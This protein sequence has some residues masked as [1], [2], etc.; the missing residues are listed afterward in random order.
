MCLFQTSTPEPRRFSVRA[1]VDRLFEWTAV[2]G[3]KPARRMARVRWITIV[4]MGSLPREALR[5][6][7]DAVCQR[8]LQRRASV[9]RARRG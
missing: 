4:A 9:A 8:L 5:A 1:P 3:I 2:P 6:L 7:I